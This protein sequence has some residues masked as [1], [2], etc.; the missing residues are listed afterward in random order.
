M[1]DGAFAENAAGAVDHVVGGQ[2]GG[3]IDDENGVHEMIEWF[4]D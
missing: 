1:S 2:S 4:G 3:L